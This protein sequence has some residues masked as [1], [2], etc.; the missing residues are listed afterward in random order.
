M[1]HSDLGGDLKRSP[2]LPPRSWST[3]V[4][5][6][7]VVVGHSLWKASEVDSD[8]TLPVYIAKHNT[9]DT[10]LIKSWL[11]VSASLWGSLYAC[12]PAAFPE[13]ISVTTRDAPQLVATGGSAGQVVVGNIFR[14]KCQGYNVL[15]HFRRGT[16][17]SHWFGPGRPGNMRTRCYTCMNRQL[18]IINICDFK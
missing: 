13:R 16:R 7:K 17:W 4:V 12:C 14:D 11:L 3:A 10:A 2:K 15:A 9:L 18:Y 8:Q 5:R 1:A 6:T